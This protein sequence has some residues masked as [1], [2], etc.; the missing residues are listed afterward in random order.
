M[1]GKGMPMVSQHITTHF[2]LECRYVKRA[3]SLGITDD[4]LASS[5]VPVQRSSLA[6]PAC[7]SYNGKL[8]VVC[9][10]AFVLSSVAG[11]YVINGPSYTPSHDHAFIYVI[12]R[13]SLTFKTSKVV[14]HPSWCPVWEIGSNFHL[15]RLNVWILLARSADHVS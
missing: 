2:I 8:H 10:A 1:K 15:W 6:P 7:W 11:M 13:F 4:S 5:L 3:S 9:D 14:I 12:F